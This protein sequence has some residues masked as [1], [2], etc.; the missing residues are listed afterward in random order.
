MI[1]ILCY[2][3]SNTWGYMPGT[4]ERYSEDIR[5][6]MIVQK[7]LGNGYT[8][9]ENGINGRTTCF[10]NGWG[11]AK[12]GREGLAHATVENHTHITHRQ[13]YIY[14]H[15]IFIVLSQIIQDNPSTQAMFPIS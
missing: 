4:G 1:R 9:I 15:I 14:I 2:G 10:E 5:W 6:P 11:E 13:I 12:N 3:D 8:V 7:H